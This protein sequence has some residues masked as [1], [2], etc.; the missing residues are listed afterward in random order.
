MRFLKPYFSQRSH[1]ITPSTLLQ[2]A[3]NE[4]EEALFIILFTKRL[5]AKLTPHFTGYCNDVIRDS[6]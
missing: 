1:R 4:R 6:P 5:Q 3:E 2:Y